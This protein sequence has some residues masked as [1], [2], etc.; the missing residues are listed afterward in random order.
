M[1][2]IIREQIA[3]YVDFYRE[4]EADSEEDALSKDH[5]GDNVYLGHSVGDSLGHMD[6]TAWGVVSHLPDEGFYEA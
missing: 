2:Y 6:P 1:K 3:C 4:V 5:E